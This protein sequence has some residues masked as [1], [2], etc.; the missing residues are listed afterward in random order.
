MHVEVKD[1]DDKIVLSRI[2]SAE[3]ECST[4]HI[5]VHTNMNIVFQSLIF[6]FSFCHEQ[7][8]SHSH[9]THPGSTQS[10]CIQTVRPGSVVLSC[11][12]T[13]IFKWANML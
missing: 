5:Q 12:F 11:V 7:V 9:R 6:Y 8:A 4:V 10:V 13:W 2:Y 1:P 3:G